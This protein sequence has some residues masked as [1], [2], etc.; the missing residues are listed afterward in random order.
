MQQSGNQVPITSYQNEVNYDGSYQYSYTSGD[1][2]QQQAKGYVK[3]VG[4]KDLAQVVQGSYSYISP[5]GT[6]ITVN[7]IAD[8]NGKL[9]G[10]KYQSIYFCTIEIYKELLNIFK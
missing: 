1:G 3:N 7:Y 5:D 9:N 10:R 8:E 2:S 4:Q 6:P